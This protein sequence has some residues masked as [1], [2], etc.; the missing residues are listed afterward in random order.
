MKEAKRSFHEEFIAY[1]WSP[2][3]LE[4]LTQKHH[5]ELDEYFSYLERHNII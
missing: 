1:Y 2:A 5:M 3:R 4:R